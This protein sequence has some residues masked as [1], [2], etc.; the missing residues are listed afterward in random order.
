MGGGIAVVK[1]KLHTHD[2]MCNYKLLMD[3]FIPV[4]CSQYKCVNDCI[5][6][7]CESG[8]DEFNM[9]GLHSASSLA[10]TSLK[11]AG[12]FAFSAECKIIGVEKFD[13][14]GIYLIT[15]DSKVKF[16]VER[17]KENDYRIVTVRSN[18][19]SDETNGS[20]FGS[21]YSSL[22]LTRSKNIFSFYSENNGRLRFERAF[23]VNEVPIQVSIGLFVQ[24]PFSK[25][26]ARAVFN[27]LKFTRTPFEHI[28]E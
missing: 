19:F 10:Y 1:G 22:I 4:R 9:P 7:S 18:P 27:H 6:F 21:S 8:Q 16:G 17:Y 26:G 28:R 14:A 24:S 2:D 11:V 5:S 25:S 13:A 3:Q 23:A 15:Q 20:V 12:D